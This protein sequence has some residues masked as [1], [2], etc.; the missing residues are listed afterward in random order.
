MTGEE[1][2]PPV[3][4]DGV[5]KV[6]HRFSYSVREGNWYITETQYNNGRRKIRRYNRDTPEDMEEYYTKYPDKS[7]TK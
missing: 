6:V 3:D 7:P 1:L 5:K 4:F 2:V